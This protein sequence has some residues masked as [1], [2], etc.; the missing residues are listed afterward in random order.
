LS[1]LLLV[2]SLPFVIFSP[3]LSPNNNKREYEDQVFVIL[4]ASSGIGKD[5]AH[6]AA[7]KGAIL[8]LTARRLDKLEKVAEECRRLGS[9]RVDVIQ[10]DVSKHDQTQLVIDKTTEWH[11]RIDVFVLNAAIPGPW[12][13]I[14]E[15][16]DT[17]ALRD[18]MDINYWGYVIPTT[19]AIPILKKSKGHIIVVS[20][21]YGHIVA[22]YQAGYCASKHAIQGFFNVLRQE[23]KPHGVPITVH[24]PGGIAT[25]VLQNFQTSN[26]TKL[27]FHMPD[28][29][30]GDSLNC[31]DHILRSYDNNMEEAYYPAY[32]GGF[33][34]I[35]DVFPSVFDYGLTWLTQ[36]YFTMGFFH[37]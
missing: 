14:D 20:S 10:A 7:Q 23:L 6:L 8:V 32:A 22:P 26:L 35:R 21:F 30:L 18:I 33:V 29:F 4:G 11:N 24:C 25:E 36:F 17:T 16:S 9:P 13:F 34:A 5:M 2:I 15:V 27:E 19:Q 28:Y 12:S 3:F 31:A 37:W 1:A